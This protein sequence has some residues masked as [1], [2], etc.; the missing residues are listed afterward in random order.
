MRCRFPENTGWV[1]GGFPLGM[2]VN[3]IDDDLD[4]FTMESLYHG[5]EFC[6][7][8]AEDSRRRIAGLRRKKP[9]ELY[10]Q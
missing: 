4:T 5:F 10:P 2:V 3:N 9:I 7:L 1:P 6:H 8:L